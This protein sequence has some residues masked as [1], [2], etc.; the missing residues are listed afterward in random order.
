[1]PTGGAVSLLHPSLQS[2]CHGRAAAPLVASR[3]HHRCRASRTGRAPTEMPGGLHQPNHLPPP[4]EPSG[5]LLPS[6]RRSPLAHFYLTLIGR[7]GPYRLAASD[8]QLAN[9]AIWVGMPEPHGAQ[10]LDRHCS[11]VC[12]NQTRH[13]S[14]ALT[15]MRCCAPTCAQICFSGPKLSGSIGFCARARSRPAGARNVWMDLRQGRRQEARGCSHLTFR[16]KRF[17]ACC[18]KPKHCRHIGLNSTRNPHAVATRWR[19]ALC[20]DV[21]RFA[22][23]VLNR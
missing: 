16:M 19:P 10:A 2:R 13:A 21:Q 12:Q 5:G 22:T 14:E 11:D 20:C 7:L 8:A 1:M 15:A 17:K 23:E 4:V 3:T 9:A 18:G 6:C